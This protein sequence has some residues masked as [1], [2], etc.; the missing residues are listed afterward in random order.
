MTQNTPLPCSVV[1]MR[2]SDRGSRGIRTAAHPRSPSVDSVPSV[3]PCFRTHLP[4]VMVNE[5]GLYLFWVTGEKRGNTSERKRSSPSEL[6][7]SVNESCTCRTPR[8][9][10][11]SS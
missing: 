11:S 1:D 8:A 4:H 3:H 9:A 5:R 6:G 7:K 2:E 10:N